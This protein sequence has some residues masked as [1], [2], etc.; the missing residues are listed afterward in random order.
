MADILVSVEN[1]SMI[2]RVI[3]AIRMLKGVTNVSLRKKEDS[4]KEEH[5]A[6]RRYSE[7]IERLRQLRGNGISQEDIENDNRLAY[8]L[9]R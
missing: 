5:K 2:D 7:R 4:L 8:L 3:E 1:T 6:T 9:N